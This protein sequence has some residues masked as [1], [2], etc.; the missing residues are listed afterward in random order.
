[1]NS[2]SLGK[3]MVKTKKENTFDSILCCI[4]ISIIYKKNFFVIN[5]SYGEYDDP[6]KVNF[7]L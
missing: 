6:F 7:G 5:T 2:P 3:K 1:M 4:H